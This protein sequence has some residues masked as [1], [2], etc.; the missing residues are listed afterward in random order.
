MDVL[1]AENPGLF[2]R[3]AMQ[4]SLIT[5]IHGLFMNDFAFSLGSKTLPVT[6]GSLATKYVKNKWQKDEYKGYQVNYEFLLG[7]AQT[8][9]TPKGITGLGMAGE[10][11]N[12]Y[13]GAFRGGRNECFSYG[14][15][16]DRK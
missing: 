4:D 3:Y 5:L 7:D 15:D 13:I 6:L 12:S 2:K 16:S 14:I 1:L 10:S 9:I 11:I 8:S